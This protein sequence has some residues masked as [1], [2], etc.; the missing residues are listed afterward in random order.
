M[1]VAR[2][3]GGAMMMACVSRQGKA[4]TMMCIC[5]CACVECVDDVCRYHVK[6]CMYVMYVLMYVK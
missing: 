2:M 3:S 1:A 4:A 6:R 5:L